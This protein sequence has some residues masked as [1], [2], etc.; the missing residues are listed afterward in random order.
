M[1][2]PISRKFPSM[3]ACFAALA[4][5]LLATSSR[6]DSS[7][8]G[9]W[10]T[11]DDNTKAE[12]VLIR[13]VYTDGV[14]TGRV[15]KILAPDIKPDAICNKCS[16]DRKDKPILGL[17]IMRGVKQSNDN[18]WEGGTI[19][20]ADDGKSY[21]VRLQPADSGKKLDVRGYIGVPLLGRTQTW[22]RVE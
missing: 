17:E 2:K 19:L 3:G 10:K 14:I 4:M 12:R 13:I 18:L 7:P 8:V 21:K 1:T 9:L 22:L 15:E 5:G 6:A 20:D 11:I 16:D